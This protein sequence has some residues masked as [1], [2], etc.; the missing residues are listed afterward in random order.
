LKRAARQLAAFAAAGCL[1]AAGAG[2]VHAAHLGSARFTPSP[3]GGPLT[4]HGGRLG[5]GFDAGVILNP[6][7]YLSFWGPTWQT[8]FTDPGGYTSA[9]VMN[10]ILTLAG[11]VGGSAWEQTLTQYCI[12]IPIGATSASCPGGATSIQN[13]PNQLAGYWIDT[14]PVPSPL[15]DPAGSVPGSHD[16]PITGPGGAVQRAAAHFGWDPNGF[17]VILLPTG[18]MP[19]WMPNYGCAYHTAMGSGLGPADESRTLDRISTIY[20]R[21]GVLAVFAIRLGAA[22]LK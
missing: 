2:P 22:L 13:N 12:G 1:L 7:L 20:V 18:T 10:Y 5:I 11:E 3:Q 4:W 9:T 17:Y 14:T 15:I 19:D 21:A 8:G 16:G 6:H